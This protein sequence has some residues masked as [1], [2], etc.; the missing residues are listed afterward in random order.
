MTSKSSKNSQKI[1]LSLGIL[2]LLT[3]AFLFFL[4]HSTSAPNVRT[5]LQKIDEE[6]QTMLKED[7]SLGYRSNPYLYIKNNPSYEALIAEGTNVLPE[8]HQTLSE[9]TE[10]GLLEYITA[11]AIEEIT[12]TDIRN[13]FSVS[14]ETAKEF[15]N[16]WTAFLTDVPQKIETLL[17]S[18]L[19]DQEKVQELQKYGLLAIP[20]L[21]RHMTT[22]SEDSPIFSYLAELVISDSESAFYTEDSLDQHTLEKMINENY[23]TLIDYIY[24]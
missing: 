15:E 17:S 6:I 12:R 3:S 2:I 9:S 21:N 18:S 24:S 8:L 23:K 11:I 14:W 7:P 13:S 1:A 16:S 22:F 5:Y 20:V 10:D 4:P 19:S